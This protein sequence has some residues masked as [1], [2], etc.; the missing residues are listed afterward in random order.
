VTCVNRL[1]INSMQTL[2]VQ[3]VNTIITSETSTLLLPTILASLD[4]GVNDASSSGLKKFD[5]PPNTTLLSDTTRRVY[6]GMTV[7]VIQSSGRRFLMPCPRVCAPLRARVR[8]GHWTLANSE[9]NDYSQSEQSQEHS[10]AIQS[11]CFDC[12]FLIEV[13]SC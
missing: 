3:I 10:N 4:S 7:I 12:K 8:Y 1:Y 9:Q 13:I 11:P 2:Q 6:Q 5:P